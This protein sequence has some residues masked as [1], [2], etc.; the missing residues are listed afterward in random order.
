MVFDT[1]LYGLVVPVALAV[2]WWSLRTTSRFPE[3]GEVLVPAGSFLIG[4]IGLVGTPGSITTNAL[5]GLFY[6]TVILLAYGSLELLKPE[7]TKHLTGQMLLLAVLFTLVF[8][9]K[10]IVIE[11]TLVEFIQGLGLV[12]IGLV[13]VRVPSTNQS[14][15]RFRTILFGTYYVATGVFLG[16]YTSFLVGQLT[17]AVGTGILSLVGMSVILEPSVANEE[18][19]TLPGSFL[20]LLLLYVLFFTTIK[21]TTVFIL[22]LGGGLCV[23]PALPR[24]RNR[25]W[26][27]RILTILVLAL[28]FVAGVGIEESYFETREETS[29]YRPYR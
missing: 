23:F 12:G 18:P 21:T 8:Y 28:V 16:I 20:A 3:L 9:P 27:S 4:Y 19:G 24:L 6:G 14:G 22:A 2:L 25:R 26:L 15:G 5:N 7:K 1:V 10:F 13:I 29:S 17:L 11:Q